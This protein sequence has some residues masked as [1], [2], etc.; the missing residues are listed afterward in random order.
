MAL[1]TWQPSIVRKFLKGFPTSACTA[2]VETDKGQAYLK[3]LG[4]PEGPHT[5]A[6][7]LV[8]TQLA[9]WFGLST[10]D[11]SI[12]MLDEIV[13]IPFVNADGNQSGKAQG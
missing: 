12:I 11:W 13:E 4:G 8:G 5:L 9:A 10:F 6:A 2:L 7:E 1:G 3:A